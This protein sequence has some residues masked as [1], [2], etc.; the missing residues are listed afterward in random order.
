MTRSWQGQAYCLRKLG[1]YSAAEQA[2]R[3]LLLLSPTPDTHFLLAQFYEDTQQSTA[4]AAHARQAAQLAPG[5][6]AEPVRQMSRRLATASFGCF[7]IPG[8]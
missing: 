8:R 5:R 1:Q 3:Q 6:F 4:A 2:Y 7:A